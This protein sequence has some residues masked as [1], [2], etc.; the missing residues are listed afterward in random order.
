MRCAR[1]AEQAAERPEI[2]ATGDRAHLL[3]LELLR[4]AER[5]GHGRHDEILEHLDVVGIDDVG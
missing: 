3:R 2:E 1:S 5:L 4:R